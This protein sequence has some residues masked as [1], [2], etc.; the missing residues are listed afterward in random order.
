MSKPEINSVCSEMADLPNLNKPDQ[1]AANHETD[2]PN[3]TPPVTGIE[4]HRRHLTTS[5]RAMVAAA[6]EKAYAGEAKERQESG[7][8]QHSMGSLKANLPE[9]SKGQAR[10][11]AANG[12]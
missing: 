10:D 12:L 7:I 1:N 4:L 2:S 8:N 9:A 5:Q 6:V 11:K 3:W